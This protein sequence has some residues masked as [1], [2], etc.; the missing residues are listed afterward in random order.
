MWSELRKPMN[1]DKNSQESVIKNTS[2]SMI[3]NTNES[4]LKNTNESIERITMRPW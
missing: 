1:H 3:K 2:E 4:M